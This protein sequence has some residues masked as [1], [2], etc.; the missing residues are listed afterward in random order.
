MQ[1]PRSS[2]SQWISELAMRAPALASSSVIRVCS[3]ASN[4]SGTA[5]VRCALSNDRRSLSRISMRLRCCLASFRALALRFFAAAM[6]WLEG[7]DP[8][9]CTLPMVDSNGRWS[10]PVSAA[11]PRL[12]RIGRSKV[13]PVGSVRT[14][15]NAWTEERGDQIFLCH[16]QTE[17]WARAWPD[18]RHY[19]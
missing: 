9:P 16:E 2:S 14:P 4:S 17:S 6:M 15:N 7:V 18:A 3:S 10:T 5:P 11:G 12:Q 8:R 1:G 19:G 13:V